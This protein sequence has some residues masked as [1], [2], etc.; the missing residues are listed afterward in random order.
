[1]AIDYRVCH[2]LLNVLSQTL[3]VLVIW[4][5]LYVESAFTI[6]T[7]VIYHFCFQER[8]IGIDLAKSA[9]DIANKEGDKKQDQTNAYAGDP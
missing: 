3:A 8:T 6:L 4:C 5:R 7:I 9:V 1:M 2:S